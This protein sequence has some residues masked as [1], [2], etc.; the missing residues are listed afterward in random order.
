M[1]DTKRSGRPPLLLRL[2]MRLLSLLVSIL[3]VVCLLATVLLVD[4]RILT[5]SDSLKTIISGIASGS[6]APEESA[7]QANPYFVSLSTGAEPDVGS[8]A[9]TLTDYLKRFAQELL[10]ADAKVDMAAVER[11]IAESTIV[12]FVSDKV[13]GFVED[14]LNGTENAAITSKE[15]MDLL[16]ENKTLIED[17][18]QIEITGEMKAQMQ[19]QFDTVVEENDLNGSIRSSVQSTMEQTVRIPGIGEMTVSQLLAGIQKLTQTR[20]L[21]MAVGLCLALMVTL[22]L[23][24]YYCLPVGLRRCG[25]ACMM[26]GVPLAVFQLIV[27]VGGKLLTVLMG[28]QQ[29]VSTLQAAVAPL[30][31]VHYGLPLAGLAMVLF[32]RMCRVFLRRED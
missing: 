12:D 25:D 3:L 13:S 17:A 23:L 20:Y 31:P 18:F 24:S 11:L 15:L 32:A 8:V 19:E 1:S 9:G 22:L 10:G 5:T 16:E 4:L 28:Q 29:M 21:A 30:A 7:A 27:Q 26:V 6:T 14:Y 2:P